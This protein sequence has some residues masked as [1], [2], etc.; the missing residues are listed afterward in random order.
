MTL[1]YQEINNIVGVMRFHDQIR[2]VEI[3]E[4]YDSAAQAL[5]LEDIP[6]LSFY[7]QVDARK[8]VNYAGSWWD[9][10][11]YASFH[12]IDIQ[13][14]THSRKAMYTPFAHGYEDSPDKR[15][16]FQTPLREILTFPF[17]GEI[18]LRP[19]EEWFAHLGLVGMYPAY[20]ELLHNLVGVS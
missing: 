8:L 3:A 4:G 15:G 9:F 18:H 13:D 5:V 7:K 2:F 11:A 14:A 12:A 16:N 20:Q 17:W 19:R 1:V 10:V 6:V